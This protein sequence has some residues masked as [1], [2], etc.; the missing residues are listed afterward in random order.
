MHSWTK[1]SCVIL[2]WYGILPISYWASVFS[3][4]QNLNKHHW[5]RILLQESTTPSI[6][7]S[8]LSIWAQWYCL[9]SLL[10]QQQWHRM[11]CLCILPSSLH[12]RCKNYLEHNGQ[13]DK[14]LTILTSCTCNSPKLWSVTV[15][16]DNQRPHRINDAVTNAYKDKEKSNMHQFIIT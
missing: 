1:G 6:I 9:Q 5:N 11:E 10:W 2:L 13:G 7:N 14:V 8:L 15:R 12:G 4:K 3:R 16:S